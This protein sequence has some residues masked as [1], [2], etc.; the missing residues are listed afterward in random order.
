MS[1]SDELSTLFSGKDAF[2]ASLY[3]R[4]GVL[5]N[6][7]PSANQSSMNPRMRMPADDQVIVTIRQFVQQAYRSQSLVIAGLQ[8]VGKT[9]LLN[10]YQAE[11]EHLFAGKAGIFIVRY[12]PDPEPS[13]DA[14]IKKVLSDLG[15]EFLARLGVALR[16][17]DE[18]TLQQ[19][20]REH[21]ASADLRSMLTRIVEAES[22]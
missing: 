5:S 16:K 3:R 8:G 18:A 7:F 11:L 4:F 12:L 13:F 19:R 20:L 22:V 14:I 17:H 1:I 6:P 21:V 10:Y 9:N 2:E 15:T